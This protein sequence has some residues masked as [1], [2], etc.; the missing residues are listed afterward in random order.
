MLMVTR[1]VRPIAGTTI[2][3]FA[4]SSRIRFPASRADDDV[5]HIGVHHHDAVGANDVAERL[6]ERRDESRPRWSAFELVVMFADEM[7]E[8]LGVGLAGESVA[9]D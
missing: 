9:I 2:S 7:R 3:R 8:H 4:T 6:P 1:R 5:G